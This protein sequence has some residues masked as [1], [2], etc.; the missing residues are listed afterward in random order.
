MKRLGLA[1]VL[2]LGLAGCGQSGGDTV[3]GVEGFV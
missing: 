3:D 2:W 1:C